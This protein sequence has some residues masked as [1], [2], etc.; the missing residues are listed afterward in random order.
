MMLFVCSHTYIYINFFHAQECILL[1]SINV[2]RV[3]KKIKSISFFSTE[4]DRICSF[5][6]FYVFKNF[7]NSKFFKFAPVKLAWN[8]SLN[9]PGILVLFESKTFRKPTSS[10]R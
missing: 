6:E 4:L 8:T 7:L 1:A 5:P 3:V 9:S 2:T 10:A